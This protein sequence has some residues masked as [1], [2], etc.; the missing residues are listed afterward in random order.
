MYKLNRFHDDILKPAVNLGDHGFN[1]ENS[2][3]LDL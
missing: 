1:A 3:F 2:S